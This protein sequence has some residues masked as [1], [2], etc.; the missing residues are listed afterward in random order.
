MFAGEVIP[1]AHPAF[2]GHFLAKK[3]LFYLT[4]M[5][6]HEEEG[7]EATGKM[8]SVRLSCISQSADLTWFSTRSH[9]PRQTAVL[10]TNNKYP[11]RMI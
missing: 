11:E 9:G 4:K 10:M 7:E 5:Y 2:D 6:N 3:W 8:Q 1:L